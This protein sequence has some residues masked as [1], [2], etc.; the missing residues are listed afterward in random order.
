MCNLCD[1]YN[2]PEELVELK[3]DAT[4]GAVCDCTSMSDETEVCGEPARFCRID[5]HVDLHLCEE[6]MLKKKADLEAGLL[7]FEQRAS[8]A[9]GAVI[10]EIEGTDLCDEAV[11]DDGEC[12]KPARYALIVKSPNYLCETH[13]LWE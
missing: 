6:H 3:G 7:E 11:G 10:K 13:K 4:T 12:V 5:P 1:P 2:E 8:L 9:L